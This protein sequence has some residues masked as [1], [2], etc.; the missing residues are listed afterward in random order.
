MKNHVLSLF[1]LI[2]AMFCC[3]TLPKRARL[4]L[5]KEAFDVILANEKNHALFT[6]RN[7]N[8]FMETNREMTRSRKEYFDGFYRV[9]GEA[10]TDL[11]RAKKESKTLKAKFLSKKHKKA[12]KEA[13]QE[14]TELTE[15][16][17]ES[18][19]K[20][21]KYIDIDAF[22]KKRARAVEPYVQL[23]ALEEMDDY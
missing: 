14:V 15:F 16:L 7:F 1:V 10:N 23:D 6:P 21:G 13:L 12:V 5:A 20:L 3:E 22:E 18:K 19:Q 9:L 17:K 2:G 4:E 11:D 8:E